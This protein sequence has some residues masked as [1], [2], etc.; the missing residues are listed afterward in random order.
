[1]II[2]SGKKQ[3]RSANYVL[4][5][6]NHLTRL[7]SKFPFP[8]SGSDSGGSNSGRSNS[9]EPWRMFYLWANSRVLAAPEVRM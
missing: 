1:M 2:L 4:F 8:A 3:L 5:P 6:S 7:S 9:V